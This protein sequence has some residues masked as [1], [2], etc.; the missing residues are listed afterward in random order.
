MIDKEM[1]MNSYAMSTSAPVKRRT[2][3]RRTH[4]ANIATGE[5]EH[6]TRVGRLVPPVVREARNPVSTLLAASELLDERMAA[7]DPNRGFVRLIRKETVRV[8]EALSDFSALAEPMSLHPRTIELPRLVDEAID[9]HRLHAK[10]RGVRITHSRSEA[11]LC[12]WAD[13]PALRLALAKLLKNA[14][15]VMPY[16]GTLEVATGQVHDTP[17]PVA[18]VLVTDDGPCMPPELFARL[19]EPFVVSPGRRPGMSLALCRMIVERLGGRMSAWNNGEAGLAV[20]VRLP[21]A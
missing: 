11:S 12:I 19:F 14:I 18:Q 17:G 5:E 3:D 16:G 1:P 6:L 2:P 20:E 13:R 15:E 10:R 7:D 21:L 8:H 4:V 9:S